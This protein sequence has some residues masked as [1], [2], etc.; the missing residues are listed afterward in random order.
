VKK[1]EKTCLSFFV[2]RGFIATH[3]VGFRVI[4][5][6][7]DGCPAHFRGGL[8]SSHRSSLSCLRVLP[9][10]AALLPAEV[11]VR[12]AVLGCHRLGV[13]LDSEFVVGLAGLDAFRR[14]AVL[15]LEFVRR[16]RLEGNMR[17]M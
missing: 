8:L 4:S 9:G 13:V 3:K 12:L 15:K 7:R 10:A 5:C 1:R 2:G 6:F 11:A 17:H 16:H 14:P